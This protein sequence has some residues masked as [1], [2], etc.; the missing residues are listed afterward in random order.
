MI[1]LLISIYRLAIIIDG[2]KKLILPIP[3]NN[4][5]YKSS[6]MTYHF[7]LIKAFKKVTSNSKG[8]SF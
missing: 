3:K 5:K 7:N 6:S 8:L 1:V 4:A 2:M